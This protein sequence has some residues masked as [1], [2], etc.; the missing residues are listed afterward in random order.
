MVAVGRRAPHLAPVEGPA[1]GRLVSRA[2][3]LILTP[4]M[5]WTVCPRER[6]CSEPLPLVKAG[7]Q[8]PA[9]HRC[10]PLL[11]PAPCPKHAPR[12]LSPQDDRWP[13]PPP[14]ATQTHGG[15]G[16]SPVLGP[17]L[18]G[19]SST[20][21]GC[22]GRAGCRSRLRRRFGCCRSSAPAARSSGRD[23]FLP[24]AHRHAWS[25]PPRQS[26]LNLLAPSVRE[27]TGW[28]DDLRF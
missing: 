13:W 27:R 2:R 26:K 5:P 8:L 4:C 12:A 10:C 22:T 6:H 14:P 15:A 17:T 23:A 21:R 28:C 11:S 1:P 16:G 3:R 19:D 24:I 25:V 9:A 20:G 18:G 7:A